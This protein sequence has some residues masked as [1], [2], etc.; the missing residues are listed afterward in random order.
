M[1]FIFGTMMKSEI[2]H[3]AKNVKIHPNLSLSFNATI[4]FHKTIMGILVPVALKFETAQCS[5]VPPG[6]MIPARTGAEV[7]H[8]CFLLLPPPP[9]LAK[10]AAAAHHK[11]K[12]EVITHQ[13]LSKSLKLKVFNI[14]RDYLG[15]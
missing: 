2:C 8:S 15:V 3:P 11:L 1:N 4:T 12:S 14:T 7:S 9:E 6:Q 5:S 10:A 13:N